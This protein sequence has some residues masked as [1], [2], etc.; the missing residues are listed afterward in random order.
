MR[1]RTTDS[2][3]PD[4]FP[5]LLHTCTCLPSSLR[6]ESDDHSAQLSTCTPQI[7]NIITWLFCS[8]APEYHLVERLCY[9]VQMSSSPRS[10][11]LGL[12]VY[13]LPES[14]PNPLPV[15]GSEF[16]LSGQNR[17]CPMWRNEKGPCPSSGLESHRPFPAAAL[18]GFP[19]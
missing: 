16:R 8:P 3:S 10:P 6:L 11:C 2:T 7:T 13:G 18:F 12:L 19:C 17:R 1:P 14:C 5:Q 9:L 15:P 4:S